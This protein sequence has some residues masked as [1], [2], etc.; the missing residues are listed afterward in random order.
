MQLLL[1]DVDGVLIEPHGYHYA[2]Q[3]TLQKLGRMCG[4]PDCNLTE[5]DIAAFE[6]NGV[7][8]EWDSSAISLAYLLTQVWRIAPDFRLPDRLAADPPP[9]HLP[10]P[11]FRTLTTALAGIRNQGWTS[12]ERGAHLLVENDSLNPDQR[13]YLREIFAHARCESG[14]NYLL[15][16]EL[17]AGSAAFARLYHLPP[18]FNAESY[19]MLYDK[20]LL[21]PGDASALK[22]WYRQPGRGAALFTARP[23][24]AP[25]STASALEAERGAELLA[26]DG[27]PIASQGK[28]AWM[29]QQ[30][31]LPEQSLIKPAPAHVLM[32]LLLAAGVPLEETV[33][34]VKAFLMESEAPSVLGRLRGAQVCIFE[35][36]STGICSL[37]SAVQR[38]TRMGI[39]LQVKDVGISTHPAKKAALQDTGAQVFADIHSALQAC[40][41][42]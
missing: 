12:L 22:A 13:T 16:Q 28:I 40:G 26:L 6:S 5:E 20:P 41:I 3:A 4:I 8:T 18:A 30:L 15:F 25:L 33:Q 34:P 37:Q 38:L 1:F 21:L 7:S 32:A 27:I 42:L 39:D 35:D 2:L 36:T 9:F 23:G 17:V 24:D 11:D 10:A 14:I 29:S 19:L 31:N